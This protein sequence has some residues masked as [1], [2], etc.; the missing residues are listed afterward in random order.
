MNKN[1]KSQ[2]VFTPAWATNEMLDFLDQEALARHESFF[3]EP[4]CGNGEMLV[5]IVERIFKALV[6]KY[7]DAEKALAETLFKFY[8]IEL[9][10]S[11]VPEARMR[12]YQWAAGKSKR[13]L[14]LLEQYLIANSLQQSIEHR[15][16]FEVMKGPLDTP[17][18]RGVARSQ[19][20]KSSAKSGQNAVE[21]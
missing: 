16:F 1:L 3:F 4:S 10:E 13:D 9:D 14:S 18:H 6:G 11:L 5:V 12:I 7:N 20:K 19:R 21:K 8:A 17:G 15:D 2:Q